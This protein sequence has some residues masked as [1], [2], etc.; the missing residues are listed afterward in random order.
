MCR[1]TSPLRNSSISEL[2]KGNKELFILMPVDNGREF[3]EHEKITSKLGV[4][5]YFA[6]PYHSWERGLSENTNGLIRQ[7]FP[8]KTDFR[9][10]SDKEVLL[11]QHRLNNRPRKTLGYLTPNEVFNNIKTNR[12]SCTC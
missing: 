3:D 4:D 6:H 7:Y 2:T 12:N 8:K 10:V 5:V 11:V 9:E 1:K